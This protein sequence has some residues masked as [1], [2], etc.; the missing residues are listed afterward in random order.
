[1]NLANVLENLKYST[2]HNIEITA[3]SLLTTRPVRHI[4]AT[5]VKAGLCNVTLHAIFYAPHRHKFTAVHLIIP[6]DSF[7]SSLQSSSLFS[8]DVRWIEFL[9]SLISSVPFPA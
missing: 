4:Y 7:S 5:H 8:L 3:V 9:L 2:L 6:T 1:L